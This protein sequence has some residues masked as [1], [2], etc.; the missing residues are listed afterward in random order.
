MK[1]P[2]PE[3]LKLF[4]LTPRDEGIVAVTSE[5]GGLDHFYLARFKGFSSFE[6]D[7]SQITL[8]IGGNNSGKTSILQAIRLFFWCIGKC[9]KESGESV[10]FQKAVF[11]FHEFRLVPAHELRELC[12]QGASP[13]TRDRGIVLRGRLRNGL[14]LGFRIYAAYTIL[15]VIEPIEGSPRSIRRED[16]LH[17]SLQPLYIPAFFGAVTRELVATDARL[18]ELLDSGH[19]NEVLRNLILRLSG[20]PQKFAELKAQLAKEFKLAGLEIP[21]NEQNTEFL[22]TQYREPGSKTTFDLVSA[23]S[24]FLQLLQILTHSLQNPAPILL[25]DEPDSHMHFALQTSFLEILRKFAAARDLQVIMASH[26]ESLVR[27]M[28]ASEIRV[29]DRFRL[30]ADR[31]HNA[32]FLEDR[33]RDLGVWPDQLELAEILRTRRVILLEGHGDFHH[34]DYLGSKLAPDWSGRRRLVQT[35]GSEGSNDNVVARVRLLAEVLGEIIEGGVKLAHYR[36]RDLLTDEGIDM[37]LAG[38]QKEK[39]VIMVSE[40]RNRESFLV[41]PSIVE[42]AIQGT[43]SGS[44][45]KAF[46]SAGELVRSIIREWCQEEVD[47]IPRK[48]QEYNI[49]WIRRCFPSRE[50]QREAE[51]RLQTFIRVEWHEPVAKG[52][53]PW[54]LVDGKE[55]L[56]RLRARLHEFGVDLPEQA[57]HSIMKPQD[58]GSALVSLVET[59]KGWTEEG[60]MHA[61]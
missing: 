35:V 8:L 51:T 9:G 39:L 5:Q 48:V 44:L 37:M 60:A 34:F 6:L 19:H 56:R 24:G 33:L 32:A 61:K 16:F 42:K 7:F 47:S 27:R 12:F 54:K 40:R 3:Q 36:D 41:E 58:Y 45:V 23:G 20:S 30:Q 21:F 13:N 15:M 53:I 2:M 52:E 55:I 28:E 31:F 29:V 38:A 50:E 49:S 18:E 17:V 43:K 11:P 46:T 10:I 57:I 26:S 1:A 22:R 59:V 14:T 4:H 25:L